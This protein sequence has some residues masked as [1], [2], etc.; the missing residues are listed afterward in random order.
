M[1]SLRLVLRLLLAAVF[2]YA[3]YTKLRVSWLVFAMSVDSYHLLPEWGSVGR[4][5]ERC[6]GWNCYWGCCCSRAHG[7]AGQRLP[8]PCSCF[9]F[10]L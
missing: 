3:A 2:L 7:C 9:S 10:S 4:R 1:R 6:L 8:P 5:S